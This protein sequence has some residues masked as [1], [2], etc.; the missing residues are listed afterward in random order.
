MLNAIGQ[1]EQKP[2]DSCLFFFTSFH[3][4][5]ALGCPRFCCQD[6]G[7]ESAEKVA[8]SFVS[9]LQSSQ[10]RYF[11]W[12]EVKLLLT[13]ELQPVSALHTAR[14]CLRDPAVER[15]KCPCIHAV[16]YMADF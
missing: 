16:S 11:S 10:H 7:Q 6:T 3:I 4:K 8:I 12:P 13:S 9:R 2:V 5:D 15:K 14:R 1:G